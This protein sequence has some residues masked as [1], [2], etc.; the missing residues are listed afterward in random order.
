V[1]AFFAVGAVLLARVDVSEGQ[2][3][4]RAG[5]SGAGAA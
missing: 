3:A 4:A 5:E 1:I 2:R